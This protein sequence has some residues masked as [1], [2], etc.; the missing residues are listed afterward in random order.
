MNASWDSPVSR[1]SML[2]IAAFA[3]SVVASMPT[4]F[5]RTRPAADS[6]SSQ[7]GSATFTTGCYG[8][9]ELGRFSGPGV[10]S[11]YLDVVT[12][13]G[14][15]LGDALPLPLGRIEGGTIASSTDVDYLRIDVTETT[16][17]YVRVVSDGVS[18]DG[19]LLDSGGNPIQT[20]TYGETLGPDGRMGFTFA[21]RLDA[22]TYYL[23]VS[24]SA[25]ASTGTYTVRAIEDITQERVAT[26][27][28]A[29]SAPFGDPLS[30]CQW[31]LKNTGQL[32]GTAGEDIDVEAVWTAGN[33]GSG[34]GVAVVDNGM[35]SYHEDLRDNVDRT[36]NHDYLGGSEVLNPHHSH[37]TAVAGI[38]AAR[39]NGLGGRGVAPRATVYG[40]NLLRN[41]TDENEADAMTRNGATTAVSNNSWGPLG[42]PGLSPANGLWKRAVDAGVTNGYGGKGIF[43]A[44]SAGNGADNDDYSN[45]DEYA[46]YYGVTAVCAVN[47]VGQRTYYSERGANLWVCAPSRD[48]GR[49]GIF[50]TYNYGRYGNRFGGTSAAAPIVSGVAALVRAANPSLTWRDVKLILAASARQNDGSNPGWQTGALQYGS[51]TERY[52]FNHQYGFGVVDARAAVSLAAGWRNLPPF[53]ESTPVSAAPVLRVPD[54][55]VNADGAT[56]TSSVTAGSEVGFIEFVEVDATFDACRNTRC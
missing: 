10:Y 7:A 11:L 16:W 56:V 5:P 12:E 54:A 53:I 49:P 32:G 34:V 28:S 19:A 37:G 41:L 55:T 30:G 52:T 20:I 15:T 8:F 23:R 4:V 38:V 46:S 9:E 24:R 36:R 51:R 1:R 35:D 21:Q 26:E 44:F 48:S 40:Y 18:I 33:R 2:R 31:H 29:I 39:D 50:A 42:G 13:P 3:S 17:V 6:R 25:G 45:L 47:D 43:Y 27:C 14:G 22:G